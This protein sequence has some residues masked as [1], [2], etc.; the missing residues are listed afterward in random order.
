[1]TD[2]TPAPLLSPADHARI[3]AWHRLYDLADLPVVAAVVRRG[4]GTRARRLDGRALHAVGFTQT[5]PAEVA[6][7]GLR[8]RELM[9]VLADCAAPGDDGA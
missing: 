9:R 4:T 6:A 2:P 7:M 8:E 1:M 5:T 3:A